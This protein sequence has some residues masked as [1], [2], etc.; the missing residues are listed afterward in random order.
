MCACRGRVARFGT[1]RPPRWLGAGRVDPEVEIVY[2]GTITPLHKEH[3]LLCIQAGKHVLVEKPMAMSVA[4][5]EAM[6]A[7]C[8]RNPQP[9]PQS[10][11]HPPPQWVAL[12]PRQAGLVLRAD[13]TPC[14]CT[15]ASTPAEQQSTSV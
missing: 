8:R 11:R 15:P 6:C 9:P 2:C 12:S 1:P 13:C 4:E 14:R 3:V 10:P 5:S 7:Q